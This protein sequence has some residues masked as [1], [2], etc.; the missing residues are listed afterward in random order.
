MHLWRWRSDTLPVFK[1][2][3][4]IL[5]VWVAAL[6]LFPLIRVL[7]LL[8][9]IG[10]SAELPG[11]E[12]F[13]PMYQVQIDTL[14]TV[15]EI[16]SYVPLWNREELGIDVRYT[17]NEDGFWQCIC[18]VDSTML[19]FTESDSTPLVIPINR[20]PTHFSISR[21]SGYALVYQQMNVG[22]I[23]RFLNRVDLISGE[24]VDFQVENTYNLQSER[25]GAVITDDGCVVTYKKDFYK[26]TG[27][28]A[29][30]YRTGAQL[31][32]GF[33]ST[34]FQHENG[35]RLL[36]IRES[37]GFILSTTLDTIAHFDPGRRYLNPIITNSG[38]KVLYSSQIGMSSFDAVS[39]T[40]EGSMFAFAGL[41]APV[42]SSSDI[43]WA[44][45]FNRGEENYETMETVVVGNVDDILDY[46]VVFTNYTDMYSDLEV[47]SVS[48][49]G[50][51]LCS[52]SLSDPRFTTSSRYLLCNRFGHIIWLSEVT[53]PFYSTPK[54][55]GNAVLHSSE[56]MPKLASISSNGQRLVYWR[57]GFVLE[58]Q[59]KVRD[60]LEV[61]WYNRI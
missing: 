61:S 33:Q 45:A 56:T 21:S 8:N 22:D 12:Y 27:D 3:G 29:W 6:Y 7:M 36:A 37:G 50:D 46:T 13:S 35:G 16:A 5:T 32:T 1:W 4:V 17:L 47:L 38:N 26:F 25:N 57:N 51:V 20:M 19:K 59:L 40:I 18:L 11:R 44:C 52:I 31:D 30:I 39:G 41:Q 24:V 15:D 34:V 14:L 28:R 2:R 10:L 48:D 53:S 43:Y 58:I 55:S 9:T 42:I 23:V 60:F 49:Y 54:T